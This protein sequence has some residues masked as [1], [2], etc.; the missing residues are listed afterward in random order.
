MSKNTEQKCKQRLKDYLD[1]G[2]SLRSLVMEMRSQGSK[3]TWDGVNDW[4]NGKEVNDKPRTMTF[5]VWN[6]IESY[7]NKKER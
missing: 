6:Q 3:V 4:L 1:K 7:L 5:R 2:N